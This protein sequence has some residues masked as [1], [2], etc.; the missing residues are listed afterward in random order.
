[1]KNYINEQSTQTYS[2]DDLL[3]VYKCAILQGGRIVGSKKDPKKP[4]VIQ[5][6]ASKD[7]PYGNYIQGDILYFKNDFTYDVVR[8]KQLVKQNLVWSCSTFPKQTSQPQLSKKQKSDIDDLIATNP[9]MYT[10]QTPPAD[11]IG[12]VWKKINLKDREGFKESFPYDYFIYEKIG[13][14]QGKSEQQQNVINLFIKQGY[15]DIGGKINP[16]EIDKYDTVDLHDKYPD[17][18]PSSYILIMP[19]ESKDTNVLFQEINQFVRGRDFSDK[20]SCR[21]GINSYFTLF[22]KSK[23]GEKIPVDDATLSNWKRAIKSCDQKI[24]NFN[25]FN[26]TNKRL[27]TMNSETDNRLTLGDYKPKTG[28]ENTNQIET[29]EQNES[30][31]NLKSIIRENLIQIKEQ[32]KKTLLEESKIVKNRLLFLTENV[33]LKTKKQKDK[34]CNNLLNEIVYLN[35][36]DF[37][38][39]VI[40]EGIFDIFSG[41]F[42][43]KGDSIKQYFKEYIAKWLLEKLDVDTTGWIAGTIIR[44]FGNLPLGDVTKLTDCNYTT[45]LIAKSLAEESIQQLKSKA[46]LEG[47]L[48]DILRNSVVESL[49]KSDLGQRLESS[50]GSILCPLLGQVSSKMTDT[51]EKMKQGAL[52][53]S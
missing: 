33:S 41:L 52:S 28:I 6:T 47:A 8:D 13:A 20:K 7:S 39:R 45:R 44:A 51:A 9:G 2:L 46:G 26:I 27:E 40:S 17:D 16:A 18:F 48:Y 14:R 35:S 25:D 12:K 50:L 36:Q 1:M 32:K 30:F 10:T 24:K 37:D 11:Q 34:F 38:K 3:N 29:G 22:N 23:S 5:K 15:K 43:E 21:Q 49:E 19:L 31:L 42:G 4:Q 53:L